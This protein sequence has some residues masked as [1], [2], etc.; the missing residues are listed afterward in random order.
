[1]PKREPAWHATELAVV[2]RKGAHFKN[3]MAEVDRKAMERA[4]KGEC[5]AALRRDGF[6]GSFPDFYRETDGF[7]ALVN[8]QFYR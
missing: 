7:V 8:F 5:V 2:R 3:C 1:M 6:K 4:L